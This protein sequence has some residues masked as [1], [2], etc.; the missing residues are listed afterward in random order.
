LHYRFLIEGLPSILLAVAVF[1]F[2]PSRPDKSRFLS[3]DERALA[4]ARLNADSL[5]EGQGRVDGGGV[6]RA[7]TDPKNYVVAV[8]YGTMNLTLGRL[9]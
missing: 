8:M 7:L 4:H 3:E 9:A 6:R 1:F 5:A 2:L